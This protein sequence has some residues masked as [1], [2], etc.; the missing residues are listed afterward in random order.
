VLEHVAGA[1]HARP[2]A[3]PDGEDAI[4]LGVPV[5]RDLLAAPDGRGREV[6]VQ[7]RH[8]SDLV[9]VQERLGVLQ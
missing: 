6:L 3:V 1:V 4:D 8:E 9:L 5:Q 7:P 2:L